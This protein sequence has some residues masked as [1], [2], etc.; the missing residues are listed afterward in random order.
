MQRSLL[1]RNINRVAK[2]ISNRNKKQF[3]YAN[4]SWLKIKDKIG[5]IYDFLYFE[6][7]K[8]ENYLP[9]LFVVSHP[10]LKSELFTE[11]FGEFTIDK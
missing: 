3:E 10:T 9:N 6:E 8:A 7:A 1:F 11:L 5:L 4:M 2:M